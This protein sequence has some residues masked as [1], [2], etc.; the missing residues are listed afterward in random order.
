MD[1]RQSLTEF[2]L[3]SR[4]F[5]N[6]D[7]GNLSSVVTLGVGDD[8]ALMSI[9]EG[10]QLALSIDTLVAGRHFPVDASPYDLAQRA[11]AVSVSDLAAMGATP[12]AF[13][14]ALTLP[15]VESSWLKEFSQGLRLAAQTYRIPL[16][17]GD[18][19][20]GPLSLTLQV[21][22]AVPTGR[23][24]RRSG[25]S[26]GDGI[27]VSGTLGDAAAALAMMQQSLAVSD[28]QQ[29]FL[30]ER[31]YRPQARLALGK[32]LLGLATA[33]ID[34]SDGL[35]ADLGHI[36]RAS[37][38]G[39]KIHTENIPLSPVLSKVVAREQGLGYALTGGDDYELCFTAPVKCREALADI[40]G[41]LGLAV[42][43]IGLL[44]EGEGLTCVDSLGQPL[45]FNST[46]YQH[47]S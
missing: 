30:L 6:I 1:N 12:L 15:S 13:T 33:A 4:Y 9:P 2:E 20:Q 10:Q 23:A 19:T 22:G 11:L 18:T 17:G 29:P 16:I 37:G 32:K 3:I 38:V 45:S 34:V 28:H 8:C 47:F 40:A 7:G 27:F 42:S 35:L 26:A 36:C 21:H 31:F 25:G 14:L 5:S 46:G 39:A 43:E 24:L 44:V 41:E